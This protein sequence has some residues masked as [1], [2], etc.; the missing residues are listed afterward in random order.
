MDY[1]AD[2]GRW[3]QRGS[4]RQ[5]GSSEEAPDM[6][7]WIFSFQVALLNFSGA[8]HSSYVSS[9]A[10]LVPHSVTRWP[11]VWSPGV[12]REE[13]SGSLLFQIRCSCPFERRQVS[14]NGL[15]KRRPL[16]CHYHR[17]SLHY[18]LLLTSLWKIFMEVSLRW[19]LN[20]FTDQSKTS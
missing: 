12:H 3:R 10:A 6:K 11:G 16:S 15:Q 14:A 9:L 20:A 7:S 19:S 17:P 18:S 4:T 5:E 8:L 13:R 1:L 2:T